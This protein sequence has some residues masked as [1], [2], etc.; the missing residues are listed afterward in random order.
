M[1][2]AI[3]DLGDHKTKDLDLNGTDNGIGTATAFGSDDQS[4]LENKLVSNFKSLGD[5]VM[6]LLQK[7][8]E[9]NPGSV[10]LT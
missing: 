4:Q 8:K 10:G 6:A 5:L 7:N 9:N 3:I 1:P 2:F